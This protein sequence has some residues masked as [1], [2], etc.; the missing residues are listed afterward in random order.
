[1]VRLRR[2]QVSLGSRNRNFVLYTLYITI[3]TRTE[4]IMYLAHSLCMKAVLIEI[5]VLGL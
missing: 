1:M 5:H 2:A 4:S 3:V